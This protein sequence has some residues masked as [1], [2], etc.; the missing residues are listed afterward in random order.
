METE[1]N[2]KDLKLGLALGGGSAL[3]FA[4]IG[5][6]KALEENSI[7]V[8]FISGTSVGAI[9]AALYAFSVPFRDIE[10]ES[11]MLNWRKIAKLIPSALGVSSNAKL[12]KILEKHIGKNAKIEDASIPLAIIATDIETGSKMVF[13][14]GSVIDAVLASSCLPGLFTPVEIGGCL[15]IDGGMVENVPISPLK[16]M[17]ADI[18][19]GV[20]LLKYRKYARPK[21]IIDVLTNSFDMINRKISDLPDGNGIDILMEPDLS[22]FYMGDITKWKDISEAGYSEA[23]KH[24]LK[25]KELKHQPVYKDLWGKIKKLFKV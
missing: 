18:I 19:V 24:I 3:G 4:H 8:D 17:G 16:N 23:Q 7:S 22:N 15:L 5:V 6:L 9:M 11:E 14:S 1:N 12:R 21:N 10:K 2:S 25:L 13:R 20:N